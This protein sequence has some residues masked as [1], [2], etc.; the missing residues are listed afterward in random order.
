MHNR[1]DR[2]NIP[3][4]SKLLINNR[5][6]RPAIAEPSRQRNL[7]DISTHVQLETCDVELH[8]TYHTSIKTHSH[9]NSIHNHPS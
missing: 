7:V 9:R 8:I 1:S 6:A 3:S 4:K 5:A 2:Y